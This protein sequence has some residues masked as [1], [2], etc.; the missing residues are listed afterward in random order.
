MAVASLDT[1]VLLASKA[2]MVETASVLSIHL[3]KTVLAQLLKELISF[4]FHSVAD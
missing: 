1:C 2:E 3:N 4:V